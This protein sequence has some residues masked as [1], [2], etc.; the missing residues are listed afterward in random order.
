MFFLSVVIVLFCFVTTTTG[1]DEYSALLLNVTTG[2]V[3][4]VG[5]IMIE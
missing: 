4:V 2:D 3:L 5:I 1:V